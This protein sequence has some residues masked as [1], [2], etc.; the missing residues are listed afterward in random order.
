MIK[1]FWT[2]YAFG[3]LE[4]VEEQDQFAMIEKTFLQ[5][6]LMVEMVEMVAMSFSNQVAELLVCMTCVEHISKEITANTA[7]ERRRMGKEELIKHSMYLLA[8]RYT[9]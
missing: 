3:F 6:F 2:K 7:E 9:K 4:A 8:Q 1:S 5:E